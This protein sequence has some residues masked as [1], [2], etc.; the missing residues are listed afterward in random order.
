M[1]FS[2]VV[3]L[4]TS[5]LVAA[6]LSSALAV[7]DPLSGIPGVT[8]KRLRS[9]NKK[10][11]NLGISNHVV[12]LKQIARSAEHPRTGADIALGYAQRM[13]GEGNGY[14]NVTVAN[15]YGTS[16]AIDVAFNNYTMALIVDSGSSDTWAVSSDFSCVDWLGTKYHQNLCGFGAAFPGKFNQPI[17]NLHFFIQYGSGEQVS[18]PLGKLDVTVAGI[19]VKNQEVALANLTYWH[20]NNYTAGL[21]GLAYPSLTSSYYGTDQTKNNELSKITY[22]PLFTEMMTQGLLEH[23]VWS[24]AINRNATDG[25]ISFGGV[26]YLPNMWSSPPASTDIII[27]SVYTAWFC[28]WKKKGS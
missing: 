28:T 23:S 13:A 24:I 14:T 7:H 4:V 17:D 25:V 2:G 27:V 18:G 22:N 12:A 9:G 11:Q 16:F 3:Q 6:I 1:K 21:V 5:G 10:P 8:F 15:T 20:G 19:T 26:P